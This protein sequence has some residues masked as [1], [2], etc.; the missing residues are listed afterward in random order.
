[1]TDARERLEAARLYLLATTSLCTR[2]LTETVR[3][4]V[5]GG[6]DAVQLRE[7]EMTDREFLPFAEEVGAVVRGTGALFLVNDRVAIARLVSADGV[8]LGQDD[9]PV[10]AARVVL[11]DEPIV[12]VS[13]HDVAQARAAE[14]SAADY[15]GVGP[16]FATTTKDTGYTPRGVELA[17]EVTRA[18][19]PPAFAIGG[20]TE[21]NLPQL[22]AAGVRR[23]AVSSAICGADDPGAAAA[24]MKAILTA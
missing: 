14:A 7:K 20:I 1:V 10:E 21:E 12:G 19:D 8:H 9:L 15:V 18:I 17:A 22:V 13:T 2:P 23:A 16:T 6:V 24:R 5:A 4:A 3:A 11:G